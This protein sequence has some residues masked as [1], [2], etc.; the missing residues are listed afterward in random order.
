[1]LVLAVVAMCVVLVG[2]F[3]YASGKAREREEAWQRFAESR[4]GVFQPTR[5][6]LGS[7]AASVEIDVEGAAVFLDTYAVSTGK[8]SV[9]YTRA[10]AAFVF[11]EGP[12]FRVYREGLLASLGKALG[13]QDVVL[14]GHARF[15]ETFVVKCNAPDAVRSQWTRELR[16]AMC[17]SL[18]EATVSSDGSVVTV[19]VVGI[20]DQHA[21]LTALVDLTGRLASRGLSML[22]ALAEIDGAR[23]TPPSGPWDRRATPTLEID[24]RGVP[25]TIEV[26]STDEGFCVDL[27]ASV[28]RSLPE[29]DVSIDASGGVSGEVPQGLLPGASE[30]ARIGSCS[31]A[32]EDSLLRLSFAADRAP[33]LGAVTAAVELLRTL[34]RGPGDAFR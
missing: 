1:M 17:D 27:T 9:S 12:V 22:A 30:L 5:G 13:T 19:V 28:E 14:G 11:G 29:I 7:Q 15:D 2:I 26:R 31:L 24:A 34:A 16:D 4:R 21:A 32:D 25:M 18:A 23:Y 3:V 20:L 33:E 6:L 8:S 10:R